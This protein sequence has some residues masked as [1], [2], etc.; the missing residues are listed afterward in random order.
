M[1]G[2]MIDT[3]IAILARS[4]HL[5]SSLILDSV[6]DASS[7]LSYADSPFITASLVLEI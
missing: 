2:H 3:V 4:L 6:S 1:N 5:Q 7:S